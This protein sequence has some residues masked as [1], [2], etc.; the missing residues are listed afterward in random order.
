MTY[1]EFKK[2]VNLIEGILIL[3][4]SD[5]HYLSCYYINYDEGLVRIHYI[6]NSILDFNIIN[7]KII[8]ENKNMEN[9]IRTIIIFM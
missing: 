7:N 5:I 9:V 6:N 4:Y 1:S 8:C 3:K 2:L